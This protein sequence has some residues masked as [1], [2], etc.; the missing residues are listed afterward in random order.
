MTTIRPIFRLH[1]RNLRLLCIL[2]FTCFWSLAGFAQTNAADFEDKVASPRF[3]VKTP[4]GENA[5][6]KLP[7]K[8]TEADVKIAGVIA[9]VTVTQEYVNE[10]NVPIEAKYV[11]PGSTKSAVY[12]MQML[13]GDRRIVA[14]IKEKEEAKKEYEAAKA[15][16]K[17]ASLLEQ[18][19]PNVFQMNV[20]NIQPGETVKITLQY[21]ELLVPEEGIY[22]FVYPTVVGPRYADKEGTIKDPWVSNPYTNPDLAEKHGI[23]T[24]HTFDI[25]VR[26]NTGMPLQAT[27]SPSHDIVADYQ[28]TSNALIRLKNGRAYEGNR[29]YVLRYQLSGNGIETGLML[30][31]GAEE[32]FFLMM[33]QPP[34]RVAPEM[35]PPRE[36]IF[37]VDV[38]GSMNGY[39]LDISKEV[40]RNLLGGLRE[41]DRFNVIL[42]AS[43]TAKL[44]TQSVPATPKNIKQALKVINEQE[45]SGN[46][47]LLN[48]LQTAF[49]MPTHEDDISR[50][51]IAITDGFVTV[52][53]EA[54]DLIQNQ[55]NKANF[56]AFGIG[57]HVNRYLIEGMAYAGN[58]EPLVI[59]NQTEAKAKADRFRQY[60]STPV[61]TSIDV[62]FSRFDAYDIQ[63]AVCSDL[64]AEK[65]LVVFGKY[66]GKAKGN[67]QVKGVSGTA[68]YTAKIQVKDYQASEANNALRSLWARHKIRLLSD[69]KGLPT[70]GKA[71]VSKDDVLKKTITNLGLK[72][73]LLTEYTSF[74]AVDDT[75]SDSQNTDVEEERTDM[76][77]IKGA[78]AYN[79]NTSVPEPHEW[80]LILMVMGL[81]LFTLVHKKW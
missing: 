32:N 29:D 62:D 42:F 77:E 51:F 6:I 52:E 80:A 60:I 48:A 71:A 16:G 4:S 24:Q 23:D 58:S 11:F 69:Y 78:L 74:V 31:E 37:I 28:T 9:D 79:S 63:P 26:L 44:S 67:I 53:R 47:Q 20:A 10:S 21:T 15:A 81:V 68:P 57:D 49:D 50:N 40:M 55:L 38:S 39:P 25:K 61:L 41:Q 59:L 54:F 76:K 34:K 22:E 33:M 45:G 8:H 27:Q 75:P 17:N 5:N 72:Y 65:P 12:G 64:F 14:K 30:Y 7:L 43:A 13:V 2:F 56:F 70:R 18:E 19:R 1:H 3:M 66:K 73:N 35:M 46:T 36:Y